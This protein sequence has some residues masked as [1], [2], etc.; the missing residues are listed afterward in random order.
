MVISA[1][2]QTCL[3]RQAISC[4]GSDN[5]TRNKREYKKYT[6]LIPHTRTHTHTHTHTHMHTHT[7]VQYR[8]G[9]AAYWRKE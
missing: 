7:R 8:T 3:R 2:L 9:S 6:K 5:Q 4:N 1:I